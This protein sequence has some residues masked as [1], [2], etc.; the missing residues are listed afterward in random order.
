[1]SDKSLAD[2]IE[3]LAKFHESKLIIADDNQQIPEWDCEEQR[4]YAITQ[5]KLSFIEGAKAMR[6]LM[7]AEMERKTIEDGDQTED[8]WFCN[9]MTEW[10]NLDR[11]ISE[12]KEPVDIWKG[13]IRVRQGEDGKLYDVMGNEVVL[14][15]KEIPNS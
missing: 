14:E 9:Y 10:S 2:Q 5:G 7:I 15:K 12:P 3:E 13:R 11:E 6:D 1:M 4:T 8:R